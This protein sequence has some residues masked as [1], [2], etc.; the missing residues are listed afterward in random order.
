M[1]TSKTDKGG[2]LKEGKLGVYFS[3]DFPFRPCQYT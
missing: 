1:E 2:S 3:S